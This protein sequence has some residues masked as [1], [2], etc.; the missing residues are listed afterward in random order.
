M[1]AAA[2]LLAVLLDITLGDPPNIVHPVAYMG[3][4]IALAERFSPKSNHIAQFFYGLLMATVIPA[5]FA[6]AGY[7]LTIAFK[8]THPAIYIA[9]IG[10]LLK[11]CFSIKSLGKAALQVK[12]ELAVNKQDHQKSLSALVSRDTSDLTPTQAASAAV[13]SVAENTTD[14]FVAPWIYFAIFGLTGVLAYRVINTL[15]AMIGYR[16][17]YEYLG[18]ASARLDDFLNLIPARISALA[19]ICGSKILNLNAGC[20]LR[21]VLSEG[22]SVSSPNAGL[23]IAAMAGALGVTLEK[24]GHYQLG[25]GLREPGIKDITD[26]V[27]LMQVVA[28]LTFIVIGAIMVVIYVLL[29]D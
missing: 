9:V 29:Q 25:S 26:S 28:A 8:D 11:M 27:K 7:F 5:L 13:E 18:K 16:G 23:T 22:H 20:A 14:S 24:K 3:K 6:A 4:L 19:I 10:I 1:N 2:L 15:D 21:L 17:K 12:T